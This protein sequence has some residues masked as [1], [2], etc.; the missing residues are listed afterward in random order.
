[1][2]PKE[3]LSSS[4][5]QNE[6][7]TSVLT[8]WLAYLQFATS[9]LILEVAFWENLIRKFLIPASANEKDSPLFFLL[10]SFPEML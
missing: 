7:C 1:M 8:F 9:P 4:N 5:K 3:N 10:L 6:V 2:F